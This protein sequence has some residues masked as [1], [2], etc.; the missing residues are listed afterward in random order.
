MEALKSPLLRLNRHEHLPLNVH[1]I[2]APVARGSS[3]AVHGSHDTW[4]HIRVDKDAITILFGTF[5]IIAAKLEFSRKC[6][7]APLLELRFKDRTC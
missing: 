7:K 2:T 6:Y 1:K 5:S 3:L 4:A